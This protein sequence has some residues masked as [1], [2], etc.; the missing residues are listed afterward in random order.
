MS[1]H[2]KLSL[3]ISILA[4]VISVA[5]PFLNYYWFQNEVRIQQLKAESFVV[6]AYAYGCPD[7]KSLIF[8]LRLRNKGVWRLI[9]LSQ[10]GQY[11]V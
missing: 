8:Q 9:P 1:R 3:A 6:H 11:V 4:L 10:V 2:E 7:K 5:S